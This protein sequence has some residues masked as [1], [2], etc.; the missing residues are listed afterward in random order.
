MSIG[1]RGMDLNLNELPAQYDI[2]EDGTD[3]QNPRFCTQVS[4]TYEA[5]N[6]LSDL[7]TISELQ[8]S[9]EDTH[10]EEAG[11]ENEPVAAEVEAAIEDGAA[12]VDLEFLAVISSPDEP[13]VGKM[14][15]TIEEARLCYNEYARKKDF[16]IR[17][18]MS[19][20][21]AKMKQLDKVLFVCNKEGI[22]KRARLLMKRSLKLAT[23]SLVPLKVVIMMWMNQKAK[24]Q[25]AQASRGKER[26]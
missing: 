11:A 25:S 12:D 5:V 7:P 16:S 3:T 22:G 1:K 9:L 8:C 26:R 14:F 6:K 21:S 19:R 15:D 20:R 4:S 2:S 10:I 18:G 23:L 24:K 13:Y 17:N